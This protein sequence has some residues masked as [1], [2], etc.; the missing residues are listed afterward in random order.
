MQ[1][2]VEGQAHSSAEAVRSKRFDEILSR[3]SSLAYDSFIRTIFVSWARCVS[4][5]ALERLGMQCRVAAVACRGVDTHRTSQVR[6]VAARLGVA[7]SE[8]IKSVVLSA[9]M[10]LVSLGLI[11]RLR[12]Q[13]AFE[14]ETCQSWAVRHNKILSSFVMRRSAV[15]A[16]VILRL[17][18]VTLARATMVDVIH[19]S[20]IQKAVDGQ[21]RHCLQTRCTLRFVDIVGRMGGCTDRLLLR[22]VFAIWAHEISRITVKKLRLQ[23]VAV[24][25]ERRGLQAH[26]G[27]RLLCYT[28]R[29]VSVETS[30]LMGA[31][32][33]MWA[34]EVFEHVVDRLLLERDSEVVARRSAAA[35]H[36]TQ[37]LGLA[38]RIGALNTLH[39]V[40]M[41]FAAFARAIAFTTS[42]RSLIQRAAE[43]QAFRD[44]EAHRSIRFGAWLA[45]ANGF[46]TTTLAY[47]MFLAWAYETCANASKVLRARHVAEQMT[48]A[49]SRRFLLCSFVSHVEAVEAL[50]VIGSVLAA[51]ARDV[52]AGM[53]GRWRLQSV[54]EAEARRGVLRSVLSA[55]IARGCGACSRLDVAFR[56]FTALV[57]AA[58]VSVKVRNLAEAKAPN[59]LFTVWRSWIR[60]TV[61]SGERKRAMRGCEVIHERLRSAAIARAERVGAI[62]TIAFARLVVFVW[63]RS[64]AGRG[65]GI[66]ARS[67]D[68]TEVVLQV[69][70]RLG[71]N[72]ALALGNGR[73][74]DWLVV[75]LLASW[76]R[77]TTATRGEKRKARDSKVMQTL[78]FAAATASRALSTFVA[79]ARAAKEDVQKRARARLVTEAETSFLVESNRVVE[80]LRR[81]LGLALAA[82]IERTAR[83]V[84]TLWTFFADQAS[85]EQVAA[86]QITL[87]NMR[88]AVQLDRCS[89]RG[90]GVNA[91]CVIIIAFAMW[92]RA[93]SARGETRRLSQR[94]AEWKE[95]FARWICMRLDGD[96]PN[97]LY[98]VWKS[99]MVITIE[100]CLRT[101]AMRCCTVTQ[102]RARAACAAAA[103][104]V[105][106]AGFAAFSR[107]VLVVW[108][109]SVAS[110]REVIV[111]RARCSA[112]AVQRMDGWLRSHVALPFGCSN[113]ADWL[114]L[115]LFASWART[116]ATTRVAKRTARDAKLVKTL[117]LLSTTVHV[118]TSMFVAWARVT[119]VETEKLSS[120]KLAT[121]AETRMLVRSNRV[122]ERFRRQLGW[123][124]AAAD[125]M[126]SRLAFSLW[127]L[128]AR[129][130]SAQRA[131]DRKMIMADERHAAQLEFSSAWRI[132]V[133]V[134][135]LAVL[136]FVTWAHATSA[137]GKTRRLQQR[138]IE[139]KESFT[140][141]TVLRLRSAV[142]D[143]LMTAWVWWVMAA[144]ASA[145]RR[146]VARKCEAAEARLM[147]A[148]AAAAERITAAEFKAITYLT[149]LA[150]SAWTLDAVV[151]RGDGEGR[152]CSAIEASPLDFEKR[153]RGRL[154]TDKEIS[155]RVVERVRHQLG[156]ALA[157]ETERLARVALTFW[158]LFAQQASVEKVTARQLTVG[159]T[160]RKAQ[161]NCCSALG[162]GVNA[163]RV[164]IIVFVVWAR[165]ASARGETR[166]LSQRHGELKDHFARFIFM[167]LHGEIPNLLY[168]VWKSWMVIAMASGE[169][170]RAIRGCTATQER[171][172]AARAAAAERVAVTGLAAFLHLALV[173]WSRSVASWRDVTEVRVRCSADAVQRMD[174]W[175]RRHAALSLGCSSGDDWLVIA[176]FV[177]WARMAERTCVAKRKARESNVVKTLLLSSAAVNL[178]TLTFMAWAQVAKVE[179]EKRLSANLTIGAE[180]RMLV[181]SNRV[182]ECL[183]R[184]LGWASA[185]QDERMSRIAI[186]A[187]TLLAR[188]A[189]VQRAADR[190]MVMADERHAAQLDF[191]SAWCIGVHVV[192]L[193]VLAFVT[194]AR[195]TSA[196]GEKRRLVQ[197]CIEMK[198]S[199]TRLT[200]L[201]LRSSDTDLL[202]T[203]WVWWAIATSASGTRSQAVRKCEA[204]EAR[205]M[206]ASAAAAERITAA[207]FKA[208]TYLLFSAFSAWTQ[209]VVVPRGSREGMARSAMEASGRINRWLGHCA[210]RSGVERSMLVLLAGWACVA[211][212]ARDARNETQGSAAVQT[213][214]GA[215]AAA[216]LV[217]HIGRRFSCQELDENAGLVI[218]IIGAWAQATLT[219][220]N[221]HHAADAAAHRSVLGR[222]GRRFLRQECA[223][224]Q[225]VP[226]TAWMHLAHDVFRAW[227]LSVPRGRE[228]D[229]RFLGI[230]ARS[231]S[232][233][234]FEE[235]LCRCALRFQVLEDER[236]VQRALAAWRGAAVAGKDELESIR[237][238]A[239]SR[240]YVAVWIDSVARSQH[241]KHDALFVGL[242]FALWARGALSQLRIESRGPSC[243]RMALGSSH[244]ANVEFVKGAELTVGAWDVDVKPRIGD[245]VGERVV[246]TRV[247]ACRDLCSTEVSTRKLMA[248]RLAKFV[249]LFSCKGLASAAARMAA[250]FASWTRATFMELSA[251]RTAEAAAHRT[252]LDRLGRQLHRRVAQ[253]NAGGRACCLL[254]ALVTWM[255][256][257]IVA[258]AIAWRDLR[259]R[260]TSDRLE[261]WLC[262]TYINWTSRLGFAAFRAWLQDIV[263]RKEEHRQ[264]RCL[265]ESSARR[266]TE[267]SVSDWLN[268]LIVQRRLIDDAR[269]ARIAVAVWAVMTTAEKKRAP[270]PGSINTCDGAGK[271]LRR[272]LCRQT[273]LAEKDC[274]GGRAL[275]AWRLATSAGIVELRV[276]HVRES[277]RASVRALLGWVGT[278]RQGMQHAMVVALAI[279]SWAQ[280]ASAKRVEKSS[281][282]LADGAGKFDAWHIEEVEL[283]NGA[284]V[285][286]RMQTSG[287][288]NAS[289]G[290]HPSDTEFGLGAA[291]LSEPY[292]REAVV[293]SSMEPRLAVGQLHPQPWSHPERLGRWRISSLRGDCFWAAAGL[294]DFA[295]VAWAR[296]TL[297]ELSVCSTAE[298]ATHRASRKR[299]L[300]GWR[301]SAAIC[302]IRVSKARAL[303]RLKARVGAW[304]TF[305]C[306]ERRGIGNVMV[307]EFVLRWWAYGA[308]VRRVE[309]MPRAGSSGTEASSADCIAVSESAAQSG[310]TSQ[311]HTAEIEI[312][313]IRGHVQDVKHAN[314]EVELWGQ[315]D[316]E[317]AECSVVKGRCAKRIYHISKRAEALGDEVV[318]VMSVLSAWTQAIAIDRDRR[319]TL[320]GIVQAD[321]QTVLR[322]GNLG[323][324]DAKEVET[325]SSPD[326]FYEDLPAAGHER[327][328]RNFNAE[329]LL[330]IVVVMWSCVAIVAKAGA[331]FRN[332]AQVDAIRDFNRRAQSALEEMRLAD[333]QRA[334]LLRR[335]GGIDRKCR[336]SLGWARLAFRHMRATTIATVY[337]RTADPER[338]LAAAF[339]SWCLAAWRRQKL[340][341]VGRAAALES[342]LEESQKIVLAVTVL[343]A[344]AVI[345][346]EEARNGKERRVHELVVLWALRTE[347]ALC[348]RLVA[349]ALWVWGRVGLVDQRHIMSAVARSSGEENTLTLERLCSYEALLEIAETMSR[350]AAVF[351]AWVHASTAARR[352]TLRIGLTTERAFLP[353]TD[354]HRGDSAFHQARPSYITE[355]PY[356]A[357]VMFM[358]AKKI[359]EHAASAH[360]TS[361]DKARLARR[362]CQHIETGSDA[363]LTNFANA[364]FIAWAR[365]AAVRRAMHIRDQCVST[366]AAQRTKAARCQKR[367]LRVVNALSLAGLILAA[368]SRMSSVERQHRAAAELFARLESRFE[369]KVRWIYEGIH[370]QLAKAHI[371]CMSRLMHSALVLWLDAATTDKDKN[372]SNG[373][374]FGGRARNIAQLQR[375]AARAIASE[376]GRVVAAAFVAWLRMAALGRVDTQAKLVG[377]L[378]EVVR[379]ASAEVASP[380]SASFEA[381]AQVV[382][383]ASRAPTFL[384]Q[385][386]AEARGQV[387]MHARTR[388][389]SFLDCHASRLAARC[390]T[391][392]TFCALFTWARSNT[393]D[394]QRR[395]MKVNDIPMRAVTAEVDACRAAAA[396]GRRDSQVEVAAMMAAFSPT[397]P[398]AEQHLRL[399][400]LHRRCLLRVEVAE[401]EVLTHV[402]VAVWAQAISAEGRRLRRRPC[403]R[404]LR[405]LVLAEAVEATRATHAV[406]G[407][408]SRAA[409]AAKRWAHSDAT[410]AGLRRRLVKQAALLSWARKAG[411]SV[412]R[413]RLGDWALRRAA[414]GSATVA[415]ACPVAMVFACW[416]R[417]LAARRT[418]SSELP[419]NASFA[420]REEAL[421]LA[422]IIDTQ[423]RLAGRELR[424]VAQAEI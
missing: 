80:R 246:A 183:Y 78:L 289:T 10:R 307:V 303:A 69:D 279:A 174:G 12:F 85:V 141:W 405:R 228:R 134:V 57:R 196:C 52:S 238:I 251:R 335:A 194:W 21:A 179:M 332:A 190:M 333:E 191:S 239:K 202:M 38:C 115:E 23:L 420:E 272:W 188:E 361:I 301:R 83:L 35:K 109:R 19:C 102:E 284:D 321:S 254:L 240:G 11:Q 165:A 155:Y 168:T 374:T 231:T 411:V 322:N 389:H 186:F 339:R 108:L 410:E 394:K 314:G 135:G 132:G 351:V 101:R 136:A 362:L 366:V 354:D 309:N 353:S 334:G 58:S 90:K 302:R 119:K 404:R 200:I 148:S 225:C 401:N 110:R 89:A 201:R 24:A 151:Q 395:A 275:A 184:Q 260:E 118:T 376:I 215:A 172:R 49:S 142:S 76:V 399:W 20:E 60:I 250:A 104:R 88:H 310:E 406:F 403:E 99:W 120:A 140:R 295:F 360:A 86:R 93:A 33:A 422:K 65:V 263:A 407:L 227:A 71:H 337:T 402:A 50:R 13:S 324:Q 28:S 342:V 381:W 349:I 412:M 244:I 79:W 156:W 292:G 164:L 68:S 276:A 252:A 424:L 352:V 356:T 204:A 423:L 127:T 198:E 320:S 5:D 103:E 283:A 297:K 77:T 54:A 26:C 409:G 125:D 74:A 173:V 217:E 62:G 355:L 242:V 232:G 150:F 317:A 208:L 340:F 96:I 175:L 31:V 312:V 181:Q 265:T 130:A 375:Y 8:R 162:V 129:E 59:V 391:L 421:R 378:D 221:V 121:E 81:Q 145:T 209:A 4:V 14:A 25:E 241:R 415:S 298:A 214:L 131:A 229:F 87:V 94:H 206:A 300:A 226:F 146:Q 41:T 235:W 187:W 195:T 154:A 70:A 152:D 144:S 326:T 107:L 1:N 417:S 114:V 15:N 157:A 329:I 42:E 176:L 177:S 123:A 367:L 18:F 311:A 358:W 147:A 267:A 290:G 266:R 291:E 416:A 249:Q 95:S 9:W 32:L 46:T 285:S 37:L 43:R 106:V 319:A 306:R 396:L 75:A 159:E 105:A 185:V 359:S 22:S 393:V 350:C 371:V 218:A 220:L 278:A 386:A 199:F 261:R 207:G 63:A 343:N 336:A 347:S 216:R 373:G 224:C 64:I 205:L 286:V 55:L 315:H 323:T 143:L 392:L 122:A 91:V 273:V 149:L 344:W 308:S 44:A 30:R 2:T 170:T 281:F 67:Q 167:R 316:A 330:D 325:R 234:R 256:I 210:A 171:L 48:H 180:T 365:T 245:D 16:A 139:M 313:S 112:E 34:R 197:R 408:W 192:G 387:S 413:A 222:L 382:R 369:G 377:K 182:V 318:L 372:V 236:I 414:A 270:H 271:A 3:M 331:R 53:V 305:A 248:V 390:D 364:T 338:I 345:A 282:D 47:V 7:L 153:A 269:L 113:G 161:L 6:S 27:V 39:I 400:Q 51:W 111:V 379:E 299:V 137:G 178:A 61:A 116:A 163:V 84:F 398:S 230:Q 280:E 166:R 211:A 274:I 368:W 56:A 287:S 138:C 213:L 346:R 383:R 253:V 294:A 259:A 243:H 419:I 385:R 66:M 255:R 341:I 277:A 128:S 189:S 169:R 304:I 384:D 397:Q 73:S 327:R 219:E 370:N 233:A 257:V 40:G 36:K 193:A 348:K 29:L 262:Y 328:P 82:E 388:F 17:A 223:R 117:L 97:L 380:P 45:D 160:R 92:E 288:D 212:V 357:H 158:T 100:S 203:A 268:R 418:K 296:A 133:H 124:L 98:P 264:V 126:M 72:A 247:E 363:R 237:A 258:K 293:H